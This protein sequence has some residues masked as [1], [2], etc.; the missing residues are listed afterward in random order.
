VNGSNLAKREVIKS[1]YCPHIAI[2]AEVRLV[3][4]SPG[5]ERAG[6]MMRWTNGF[7]AVQWERDGCT[8]GAR[9]LPD[10]EG[11]TKARE[12]FARLVPDPNSQ[13]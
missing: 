11:E 6:S 3:W 9:Y 4:S 2:R 10:G 12:H 7:W 8:Y 5:F 1:H 13:E